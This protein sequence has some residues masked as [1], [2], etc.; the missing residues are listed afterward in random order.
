MK[1]NEGGA[2]MATNSDSPGLVFRFRIIRSMREEGGN[3]VHLAAKE[4]K[5]RVLAGPFTLSW[6]DNRGVEISADELSP[7]VI[8]GASKAAPAD[9]ALVSL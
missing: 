6:F 2:Y 9:M 5:K 3:M 1:I 7:F 8:Y 4:D